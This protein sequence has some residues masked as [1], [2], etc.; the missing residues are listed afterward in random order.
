MLFFDQ[1][2]VGIESGDGEYRDAT[3][4]QRIEKG[5]QHSGQCEREGTFQLEACPRQF[6]FCILRGLI[7]GADDGELFGCSRNG[8]K[9]PLWTES[10]IGSVR[11][12]TADCE[13]R[14]ET[15]EFQLHDEG[16]S[17]GQLLANSAWHELSEDHPDAQGMPT[18]FLTAA[19]PAG[20]L[21][22]ALAAMRH[23][24]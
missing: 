11:R 3:L 17:V 5:G 22:R 2:I 18:A 21:N 14:R 16:I 12:Q 10:G 19:R 13:G 8:G 9:S 24:A 7:G 4:G 20:A 23:R 1:D 15:A 6:A